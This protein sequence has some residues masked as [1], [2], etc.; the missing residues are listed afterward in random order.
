M[1]VNCLLLA[2]AC[3]A[4]APAWA[5]DASDAVEEGRELAFDRKKGNCLS[6]HMVPGAEEPGNIA[7][8]LLAMESRFPDKEVLR[9]NIWDQTEF[10]PHAMMPPFGKHGILSE[11]EI[12]KIVEYLYTL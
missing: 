1:K 11:D 4:G 8:A 2:L 7:V 6:C 9:R 12:D 10:R 3:A 5:A